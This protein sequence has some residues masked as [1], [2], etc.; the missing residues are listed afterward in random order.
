VSLSLLPPARGRC[1]QC[2]EEHTPDAPHNFQSLYWAF[3]FQQAHGRSPAV[4]DAF[5]HCSIE[6][7][8]AWSNG[9]GEMG[10]EDIAMQIAALSSLKKSQQVGQEIDQWLTP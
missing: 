4:A 8:D 6:V 5:E 2:A 7:C 9:L 3:W 10:H 1:Q